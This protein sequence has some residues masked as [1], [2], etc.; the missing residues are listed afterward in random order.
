MKDEDVLK[1]ANENESLS[2][3]HTH[4]GWRFLRKM[5]V[6]KEKSLIAQFYSVDPSNT[7]KIASI[8]GQLQIIR[9]YKDK[10]EEYFK[11]RK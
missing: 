4:A 2:A 3:L 10:P 7:A 5:M 11:K 1:N 6:E 9:K 8:Q